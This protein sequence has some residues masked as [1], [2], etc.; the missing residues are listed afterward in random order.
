MNTGVIEQSLE[1]APN[2]IFDPSEW[3]EWEGDRL[4]KRLVGASCPI[5]YM[6]INVEF[7]GQTSSRVH[8]L[9]LEIESLHA[10]EPI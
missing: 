2:L 3:G 7:A 8:Y 5:M 6:Y 4:G 10:Y 1:I 9:L